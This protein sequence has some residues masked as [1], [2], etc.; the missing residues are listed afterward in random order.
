MYFIDHVYVYTNYEYSHHNIVCTFRCYIISIN[1][2][3]LTA[4]FFYS[5]SFCL[6][7]ILSFCSL[8]VECFYK[9]P[10][11]CCSLNCIRNFSN[12][13]FPPIFISACCCTGAVWIMFE[14]KIENKR[15]ETFFVHAPIHRIPMKCVLR[16]C[17]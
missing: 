5:L 3:Y 16:L 8:F 1:W 15:E 4:F 7:F 13:L 17:F 9:I 2:W 14:L 10:A 12:C 11:C 6:S